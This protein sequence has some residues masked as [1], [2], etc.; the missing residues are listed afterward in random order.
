MQLKGNSSLQGLFTGKHTLVAFAMVLA[1]TLVYGQTQA[2]MLDASFGN[3]GTVTTDFAGAG[4]GA[5]AVA[6][7]PDGKIVVAGTTVVGFDTEFAL[8]RY[9]SNG[10]LDASFGAGGRVATAFGGRFEHATSVAI[11]IDGKIVVA[12]GS[13]VGLFNDFALARYNTDGTLDAGFGTGGKVLTGFGVSAQAYSVA[14]QPD[15]KIVVA[16]EANIDGNF[17][18]ELVRYNTDG[19]LDNSFGAGGK[20]STDF[21]L[22]EQGYSYA[23]A[24]S[25]ALQ[26]D[27]KIVLA[28]EATFGTFNAQA[29]FALA[30]YNS[31]GTLDASFGIGGKVTTNV[32]GGRD[33][34][35]SVAIQP[36]G[37]IV[38][39]GFAR[40]DFALA[41]YT[42]SG[43][44]D[45]S[46]GTGGEVTTNIGGLTDWVNTIGLEPDGKIIA[47]GL[48]FING[49]FQPALAQYNPSGTLDTSFGTGGKLTPT[50]GSPSGVS[51]VAVQQDGKIVVAGGVAVDEGSSDFLLAR[52]ASTASEPS[53][54][55]T[56][57]SSGN[58]TTGSSADGTTLPPATQIVDDAGSV[59]MIGANQVIL[60]NGSQAA[61]GLGF[62]ILWRGGTIYVLG[63]DNNWWQWTGAGWAFV[64]SGQSLAGLN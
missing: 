15:G 25:L 18:F 4:D 1:P 23:L 42:P 41:R 5:A 17:D 63:V 52:Y 20:V 54:D 11:G 9:N 2:G 34:A 16:G 7:Q 47:V 44:L 36:D 51:S 29:D 56:S 14:V 19:T 46:F 59:W 27:G 48:T 57:G 58:G 30:R 10:T 43:A 24:Y 61:G 53:A 39:G 60:R 40:F 38:A 49:S 33:A 22:F 45:A 35:F 21:G 6:I 37:N 31:D 13:V 32:G 28:G 64:G 26:P 50:F 62:Q 12:G 3:G 8:A 55:G